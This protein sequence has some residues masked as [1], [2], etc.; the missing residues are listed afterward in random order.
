MGTVTAE[1]QRT[2]VDSFGKAITGSLIFLLGTILYNMG[3]LYGADDE[4]D[5]D[6]KDFKRNVMGINQ[7]SVKM[8]NDSFSV[9]W[10]QPVGGVLFSGAA[11][12]KGSTLGNNIV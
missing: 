4:K 2:F 3:K 7:Y 12:A 9:D 6:I 1:M 11:M 10:L 5:K 8:G